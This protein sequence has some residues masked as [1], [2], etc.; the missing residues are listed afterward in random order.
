METGEDPKGGVNVRTV[1]FGEKVRLAG[2]ESVRKS[3]A[4]DS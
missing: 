1:S 4:Q 2:M 3:V